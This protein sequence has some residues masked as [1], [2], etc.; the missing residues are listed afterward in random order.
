M[1]QAE[2]R[3]E[4]LSALFSTLVLEHGERGGT[5]QGTEPRGEAESLQ[6]DDAIEG[7]SSGL[8]SRVP[9]SFLEEDAKT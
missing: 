9:G 1:F 2:A 5:W 3:E 4:D 8:C 7:R 6:E